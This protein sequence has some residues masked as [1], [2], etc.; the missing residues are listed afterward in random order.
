MMRPSAARR[1]ARPEVRERRQR[2]L[3]NGGSGLDQTCRIEIAHGSDSRKA[4]AR[5]VLTSE[6]RK[7]SQDIGV[8]AAIGIAKGEE[9]EAFS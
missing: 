9:L 7:L 4:P 3:T 5:A 2:S 1:A 8:E 6:A